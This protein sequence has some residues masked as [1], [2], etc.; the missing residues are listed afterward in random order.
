VVSANLH[1]DLLCSDSS[2]RWVADV[3]GGYVKNDERFC[4]ARI[5]LRWMIR[6]CFATNTG[7]QF[8]S[9]KLKQM[10]IDL[11]SLY[12]NLT[13]RPQAIFGNKQEADPKHPFVSEE[14]EDLCDALSKMYDQLQLRRLWW[15]LEILPQRQRYQKHDGKW[16]TT[17]RYVMNPCVSI[18]LSQLLVLILV[19][20]PFF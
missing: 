12:P 4:L 3:G 16:E 2:L 15:I 10:G 5:P 11:T 8:R 19:V 14:H 18:V 20:S 13:P 1:N 7:I 6:E 9:V 17:V